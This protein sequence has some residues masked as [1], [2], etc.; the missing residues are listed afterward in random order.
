MWLY[1]AGRRSNDVS[2]SRL[3]SQMDQ[4][5]T[6]LREEIRQL[7]ALYE[8]E[9]GTLRYCKN[10]WGLCGA[11]RV[12]SLHGMR[13]ATIGNSCNGNSGTR[14]TNIRLSNACSRYVCVVVVVMSDCVSRLIAV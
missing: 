6:S 5:K 13:V 4:E 10:I 3:Q 11:A 2:V 12:C 7:Q 8:A 9:L 1:M 14:N